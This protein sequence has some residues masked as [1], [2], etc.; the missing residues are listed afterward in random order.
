MPF[1][2]P[3]LMEKF[4]W[5]LIL[6]GHFNLGIHRIF[7]TLCWIWKVEFCAI[8]CGQGY[9][10]K[11]YHVYFWYKKS[12]LPMERGEFFSAEF[13]SKLSRIPDLES[14]CKQLHLSQFW[15]LITQQSFSIFLFSSPLR[16]H[17]IHVTLLDK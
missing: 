5:E 6:V 13:W 16:H 7:H 1:Y 8:F 9:R 11:H 14:P 3:M 4:L 15:H 10:G 12:W 17:C 2:I